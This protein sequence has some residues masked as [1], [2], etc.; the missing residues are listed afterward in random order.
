MADFA[1]PSFSLGLD[2]DLDPD[3]D[4]DLGLDLS[5]EE[6]GNG[7]EE[8]WRPK[9][10]LGEERSTFV[11]ASS[12]ECTTHWSGED[13]GEGGFYRRSTGEDPPTRIG[14]FKRLRRGTPRQSPP[15]PSTPHAAVRFSALDD[16]IED[17]S[18]QEDCVVR[19][20]LPSR[21]NQSSCSSSK[22]SLH[23]QRVL[24]TTSGKKSKAPRIIPTSGVSIPTSVEASSN[25]KIFPRLTV[26][27]L[28]RIQL[29]DSDSDDLSI[30]EDKKR[31]VNGDH[32]QGKT[33]ESSGRLQSECLW[34]DFSPVKNLSLPT[35]ALDQYC[36]DYFKEAKARDV[37][38]Q[39][40]QQSSATTTSGVVLPHNIAG[41]NDTEGCPNL[42][43]RQPPSYQY[44]FHPDV[45][46]QRLVQQRLPHFTPIGDV[47]STGNGQQNAESLDYISSAIPKDAA[48]RRVSA[49]G[50]CGHWFTGEDG[51]KVY[52]TKNGQELSGQIAY[53]QYKKEIG[54]SRRTGKRSSG[55]S[56]KKAKR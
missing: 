30:D 39:S 10:H 34:V 48:K 5:T 51:R 22:F 11:G 32:Q 41:T 46:I 37:S 4:P 36:E 56:R 43:D 50:S 44:F 16:D 13:E 25:K 3:P 35:P 42:P 6:E 8:G 47:K 55:N 9:V 2:L 15:D 7:D 18:S 21:Q 27:P 38:Q 31:K 17:F 14:P 53:R 23:G 26:S 28:K 19:D 45:R 24:T 40:K 12:S 49:V 54:G 1:G 29:L 33:P 20:A 52:V